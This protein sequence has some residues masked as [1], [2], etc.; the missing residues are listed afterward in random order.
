MMCNENVCLCLCMHVTYYY[1]YYQNV[2]HNAD[3]TYVY[4]SLRCGNDSNETYSMRRP[5]DTKRPIK[6]L[7]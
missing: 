3:C 5:N 7:F 6:S 2:K 4:L 1:Y